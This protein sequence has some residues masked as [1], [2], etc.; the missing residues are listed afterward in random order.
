[1]NPRDIV[2]SSLLVTPRNAFSIYYSSFMFI[3][4]VTRNHFTAKLRIRRPTGLPAGLRLTPHSAS[5][6]LK[7]EFEK[8]NFTFIKKKRIKPEISSSCNS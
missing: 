6:N 7:T 3:F 1:M 4:V 2:S 5:A 8:R